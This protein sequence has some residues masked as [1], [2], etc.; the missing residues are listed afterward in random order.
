MTPEGL[1]WLNEAECLS[2]LSK[3]QFG[4]I[5]ISVGALPAILPVSYVLDDGSILFWSSTGTKLSAAAKD[6]VVAFECDH[7]DEPGRDAWS[8]LA[9]GV[10]REVTDADEMARARRL[11]LRTWAKQDGIQ[12]FRI[13]I[14]L[15]SGRRIFAAGWKEVPT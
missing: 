9:I 7:L 6:S 14:E 2:L 12:L 5:G 4:R 8:V 1:E 13:P 11:G 10:A 3:N 15:V